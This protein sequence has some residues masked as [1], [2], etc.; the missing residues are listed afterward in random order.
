[1]ARA[2]DR[3]GVE[4][5]NEEE[6]EEVEEE[7]EALEVRV[8]GGKAPGNGIGSTFVEPRLDAIGPVGIEE[9]DNEEEEVVKGRLVW[10][11]PTRSKAA[12]TSASLAGVKVVGFISPD[13]FSITISWLLPHADCCSHMAC[14]FKA[15]E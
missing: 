11:C 8:G 6:E 12:L 15:S 2:E 9:E 10:R 14:S 1:M 5:M 3:E 4:E 7:A 13:T